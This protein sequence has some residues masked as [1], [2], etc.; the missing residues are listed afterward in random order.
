[1]LSRINS[2]HAKSA[3]TSFMLQGTN[4]GVK[5]GNHSTEKVTEML[6]AAVKN[7]ERHI[8]CTFQM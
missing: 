3:L 4:L 7:I 6:D 2:V 8:R 1:M 5:E